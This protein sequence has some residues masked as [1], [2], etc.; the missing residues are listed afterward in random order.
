MRT[1]LYFFFVS[2]SYVKL[3]IRIAANS[4]FPSSAHTYRLLIF[5]EP[6]KPVLLRAFQHCASNRCVRKQQ[7]DE[8]MRE[9]L[10]CVNCFV[11]QPVIQLTGSAANTSSARYC[12]IHP[13]IPPPSDGTRT[14][15]NV[16][17]YWQAF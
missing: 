2:T 17:E 12:L 10:K 8:I 15:S 13:F 4:A 7:R 5:K 11:R 1:Y 16:A 6:A 14:I 3:S 9:F